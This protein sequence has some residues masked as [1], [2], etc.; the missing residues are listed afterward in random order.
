[1]RTL[2]PMHSPMGSMMVSM[3]M[4][5]F[6]FHTMISFSLW[7]MSSGR[8]K[9]GFD[10]AKMAATSAKPSGLPAVSKKFDKS[11]W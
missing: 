1:M 10:A 5:E 2:G 8:P 9:Q 6:C 3:G 4:T 7:C 11:P